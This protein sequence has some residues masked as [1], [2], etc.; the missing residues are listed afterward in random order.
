MGPRDRFF[1]LDTVRASTVLPVSRDARPIYTCRN[2]GASS[3]VAYV[4]AVDNP[5]RLR[6]GPPRFYAE[7]PRAQ[8]AQLVEQRIENPRVGGSI[9]SLGTSVSRPSFAERVG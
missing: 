8:V 4:V 9:P 6:Q 5:Q 2:V 7:P 3:F 1:C